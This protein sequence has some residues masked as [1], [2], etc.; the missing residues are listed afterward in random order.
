MKF[1]EEHATTRTRQ[2]RDAAMDAT[3]QE[4]EERYPVDQRP[5]GQRT[6]ARAQLNRWRLG[7][8]RAEPAG[9]AGKAHPRPSFSW[10]T[11]VRLDLKLG[12]VPSPQEAA[13]MTMRCDDSAVYAEEED[14][15]WEQ[16]QVVQG[17]VRRACASTVP[18]R[19]LYEN[20]DF[21]S[22]V[23][24]FRTDENGVRS[25]ERPQILRP[26]SLDQLR[27]PSLL[28]RCGKGCSSLVFR[29][30][31]E[32]DDLPANDSSHQA[33]PSWCIKKV[34]LQDQPPP[35]DVFTEIRALASVKHENVR[36]LK[37]DTSKSPL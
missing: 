26:P 14:G 35:H 22:P 23:S 33:Y 7:A 11:S 5:G 13:A 29:W 6:V 3:R 31:P 4:N 36:Q 10:L 9:K 12:H 30:L 34:E 28:R 15:K 18:F 32:A 16:L 1:D 2:T 25:A 17:D 20:P 27:D 19:I 21:Y 37:K 8:G 24:S